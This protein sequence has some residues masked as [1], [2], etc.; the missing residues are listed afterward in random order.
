MLLIERALTASTVASSA[1]RTIS[2]G[3]G[4]LERKEA[5]RSVT[6]PGVTVWPIPGSATGPPPLEVSALSL[7]L[8]M[9][10]VAEPLPSVPRVILAP[11]C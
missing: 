9:L 3:V 6:V 7:R 5:P 11:G 10:L 4:R 1:A 8:T 2:N